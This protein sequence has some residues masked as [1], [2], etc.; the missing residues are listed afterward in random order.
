MKFRYNVVD[1]YLRLIFKLNLTDYKE[2]IK[3]TKTISLWKKSWLLVQLA[4]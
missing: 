3:R 4:R 1:L 2:Q